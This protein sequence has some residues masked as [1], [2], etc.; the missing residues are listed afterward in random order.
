MN[1]PIKKN[2]PQA[3]KFKL[4]ISKEYGMTP[5]NA[6]I[7]AGCSEKVAQAIAEIY[8]AQKMLGYTMV[9]IAEQE[10]ATG[11]RLIRWL[12]EKAGI[13]DGIPG[14]SR[15]ISVINYGE[16]NDKAKSTDKEFIDVPDYDVQF[17]CIHELL[18]IHK[19][20]PARGGGGPRSFSIEINILGDAIVA[21]KV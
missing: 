17:K 11:R 21:K 9:D 6:A 10:Q 3:K 7:S 13:V 8:I 20:D 4:F 12:S 15:V 18:E 5:Y 14:A 19:A 1:Y 2:S 16:G